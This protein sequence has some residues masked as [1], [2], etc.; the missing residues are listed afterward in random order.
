MPNASLL[1]RYCEQAYPVP[2]GVKPEDYFDE[3]LLSGK[4]PELAGSVVLSAGDDSVEY[5][6]RK[7][8]VLQAEGYLL[9]RNNP[10][11]IL[12][13]LDK[14]R[15]LEIASAAKVPTPAF[16]N[17]EHKADVD[18]ALPD[19]MYP[20]M[21][22]PH[23]SH[24]FQ[25]LYGA[26]YALA[27]NAEELREKGYELVERG[28]GFMICEMI[29]GS[30][31][32][33]CSYYTY[34]DET[35]AELF[36][37]TK[38]CVR[39]Y[40]MNQGSGTYQITEHIPDVEVMARRFFDAL[41]YRGIGNLEFKRDPRDNQLKVIECNTRF[42]AVQEQ[43]VQSGVEAALIT[44]CH[45]TGQP[46]APVNGCEPLVAIWSPIA[47]LKAFRQAKNAL[48]LAWGDWFKSM[49]HK[50]L[51][52]P[53]FSFSD[54]LPAL[55]LIADDAKYFLGRLLGRFGIGNKS[56]LKASKA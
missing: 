51:V 27:Q 45:I 22:K 52:F 7:R 28:I 55:S 5:L 9:E 4:Y 35:G 29:P 54:P 1:S 31:E 20:A 6:A 50:K 15:T 47:D 21:L 2:E 14:Q 26:K 48:G 19:A 44:Y 18:A 25:R 38:R 33:N 3:L 8:D 40:P 32:Q 16:W 13:L 42:T 37:F 49:P 12:D 23:Y 41:E 56:D 17:V 39:R 36:H 34:R 53:Y 43:L 11:L 10:E 46:V 24:L 30:D